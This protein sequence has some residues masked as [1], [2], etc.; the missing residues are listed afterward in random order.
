MFLT[1]RYN[2]LVVVWLIVLIGS[3]E[4]LLMPFGRV[5][6]TALS[7]AAMHFLDKRRESIVF[8][9]VHLLCFRVINA[10]T[11]HFAHSIGFNMCI[12]SLSFRIRIEWARELLS[13]ISL[14]DLIILLAQISKHCGSK[15]LL[16]LSISILVVLAKLF[17]K[18]IVFFLNH[19]WRQA[20]GV[21][22]HVLVL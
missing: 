1:E 3:T 11:A 7:H 9:L 14:V 13:F 18:V 12:F 15:L 17:Q 16:V 6:A 5:L 4:T 21:L 10:W 19:S 22:L 20:L 8:D 2:T